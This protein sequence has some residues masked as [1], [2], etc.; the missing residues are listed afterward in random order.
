MK[1][2]KSAVT[3]NSGEDNSAIHGRIFHE[4]PNL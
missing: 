4:W 2:D 3:K 1:V